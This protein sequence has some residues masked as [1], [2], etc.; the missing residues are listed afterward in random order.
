MRL[1]AVILLSFF[2]FPVWAGGEKENSSSVNEKSEIIRITDSMGRELEIP[3]NPDHVICSGSGSL[4]LLVYLQEQDRVV[5]VDDIETRRSKF[6]ARPYAI[7]NPQFKKLPTFGEFRGHDNPELILSLDPQPDVI[8]KTYSGMG[9]DPV[10]L[11][12]K[13]GIPVVVLEYGNITDR[14]DDLYSSLRLMGKILGREKRAEEVVEFMENAVSDLEKRS[15]GI[16]EEK[17]LSCYVGGIAFKGPHGIQSTEPAYPPFLFTGANNVAY[18]PGKAAAKQKHA[19]I[20][21][22]QI[23]HWDP[24][25]LFIDVSTL[26][27]DE[28]AGALYELQND[29]IYSGM[30]SVREGN[31]YGVLPYNWYTTNFG[32]VLANGYFV[33]KVLYPEYYSDIDPEEKADRIYEFLTGKAVFKDL[34]SSFSGHAFSGIKF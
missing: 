34:D 1:S 29:A 12:N 11:Q 13:T 6:D 25:V 33:G 14:R 32:S 10:E 15:S 2:I 8:F 20:A 30:K 23:I 18:D 16:P 5:A 27:S 4:R 28:K 24:D 9:Y 19:D 21:K 31:I 17:K 22:E 26:Q 3:E 7:A